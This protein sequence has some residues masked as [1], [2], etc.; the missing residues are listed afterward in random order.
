MDQRGGAP[1]SQRD[2]GIA[3]KRGEVERLV[4]SAASKVGEPQDRLTRHS[5]RAGLTM[6]LA[7]AGFDAT[8]IKENQHRRLGSRE[9]CWPPRQAGPRARA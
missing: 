7:A 6:L 2:D 4:R 1:F 8:Y 9:L 3:L 5:G